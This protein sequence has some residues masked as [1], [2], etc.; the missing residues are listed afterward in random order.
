MIPKEKSK[1][2]SHPFAAVLHPDEEIVWMATPTHPSLWKIIRSKLWMYKVLFLLFILV[3]VIMAL[4]QP[5]LYPLAII[6]WV[7]VFLGAI[8]L[9]TALFGPV[10]FIQWLYRSYHRQERFYAVTNE[11]V[12]YRIKGRTLSIPLKALPAVDVFSVDERGSF[13]AYYPMWLNDE[14]LQS[15]RRLKFE[16]YKQ[17]QEEK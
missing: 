8:L 2:K 7:M 1:G 9:Q 5:N 10:I 6:Q 4:R 13:G 12:L 14:D 16:I 3:A 11:R 17:N 15:I